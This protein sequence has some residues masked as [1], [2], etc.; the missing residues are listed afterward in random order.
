[1]TDETFAEEREERRQRN[2]F[3]SHLNR[4]NDLN[5]DMSET[6]RNRRGIFPRKNKN[7]KMSVTKGWEFV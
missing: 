7:K 1:M 4:L 6:I 3:N 2:E 5:Y